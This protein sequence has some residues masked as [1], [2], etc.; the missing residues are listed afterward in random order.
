MPAR[1]DLLLLSNGDLPIGAKLM[2]T[3]ESD[4]QIQR[5]MFSAYPGEWKQFPQNGVGVSRYLKSNNNGILTLKSKA[6]QALLK[7]GYNV[8]NIQ[9][10]FTG[11][12]KL[13]I[14]TNATR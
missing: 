2:T 7:D 11:E 12:N 13:I 10:K 6:R 1:T 3:G 5:D 9:Y 4:L 8:G 14:Y